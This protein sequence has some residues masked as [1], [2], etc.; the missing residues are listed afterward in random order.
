MAP[1]VFSNTSYDERID[2][3][4]FAIVMF[5]VLQ[6]LMRHIFFP[7]C[8]LHF[9][10]VCAELLCGVEFVPVACRGTQLRIKDLSSLYVLQM[11]GSSYL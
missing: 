6:Y 4:S 8:V 3:F 9:H 2:I 7:M 5:E 10:T 11:S 1:E